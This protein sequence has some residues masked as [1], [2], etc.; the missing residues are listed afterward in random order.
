MLSPGPMLEQPILAPSSTSG[1]ACSELDPFAGLYIRT[2]KLVQSISIVTSI[3]RLFTRA[4]SSS[5]SAAFPGRDSSNDYLEIEVSAC[6]N[7]TEDD[8]L[9]LMVAPNKNQSHNNFSGY[10]TLGRSETSDA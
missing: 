2:A 5:L 4:S 6:E 3:L 10:P 1:G 8:R 9:I 7:S